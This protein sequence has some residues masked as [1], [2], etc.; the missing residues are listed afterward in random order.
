MKK[1]SVY[2]CFTYY[3]ILVSIVKEINKVN[4]K[5]V[6]III[7]S[8]IPNYELISKSLEKTNI[9]SEIIFF[10]EKKY[11][12]NDPLG[13][14]KISTFDFLFFNSFV[15]KNIIVDFKIKGFYKEVNIYNDATNLGYYLRA[16]RIYYNLLEDAKDSY[17]VLKN[18][19]KINYRKKLKYNFFSFETYFYHGKSKFSKFV[20]VND[21]NGL[22]IPMKKVLVEN[23]KQMFEKLTNEQ[24]MIIYQIFIPNDDVPIDCNYQSVLILT[25]PL[26]QDNLVKSKEIHKQIYKDI[27]LNYCKNSKVFIKPHPRDDFDYFNNFLNVVVI[28]KDIPIEILNFNQK[29]KFKTAIT[30]SSSS[31]YGIEFISQLI[32][33]G[34]EWL[35]NY[36]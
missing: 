29:V 36:K 18:Y 32:Y 19:M 17:K 11:Q 7:C 6:D 20:E 2:I 16:N 28:D 3:H 31:I 1:S 27:L 10:D 5:L 4:N 35:K 24:K 26:F 21:S 15:K 33:L 13:K 14:K 34:F 8:T 22:Q 25:Q 30:V 12:I 23:K 9:F